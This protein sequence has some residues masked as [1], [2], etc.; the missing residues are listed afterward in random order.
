MRGSGKPT[1][2]SHYEHV[3]KVKSDEGFTVRKE[4]LI[5]INSNDKF[6][7][8]Y[9]IGKVIGTGSLGI[10]R[11]VKN[12]DTEAL[13]AVKVIKKNKINKT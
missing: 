7:E 8:L 6:K 5:K 11:K 3:Q 13:R 12:R 10:V 1:S 9:S 2:P 4:D